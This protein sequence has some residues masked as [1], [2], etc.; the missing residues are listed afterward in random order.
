MRNTVQP[1]STMP[2]VKKHELKKVNRRLLA[3]A[4]TDRGGNQN[5]VR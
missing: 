4:K 5:K 2:G 1:G 3:E